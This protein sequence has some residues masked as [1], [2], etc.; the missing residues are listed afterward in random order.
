MPTSWLAAGLD[1]N[2]TTA[3]ELARDSVYDVDVNASIAEMLNVTLREHSVQSIVL[4]A[5]RQR[6]LGSSA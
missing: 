6:M 3:G 2:A 1:P 5:D 4:P